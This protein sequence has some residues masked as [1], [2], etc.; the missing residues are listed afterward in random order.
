MTPIPKLDRTIL[1]HFLK[2]LSK[3]R[4][5]Q[6]VCIRPCSWSTS[7]YGNPIHVPV[8]SLILGLYHY[9]TM[10]E[11]NLLDDQEDLGED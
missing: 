3:Q 6:S 11:N 5:T 10:E 8:E 7:Q 9:F 1:D 4:R 2:G